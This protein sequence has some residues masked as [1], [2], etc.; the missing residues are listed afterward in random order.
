MGLHVVGGQMMLAYAR[1]TASAR[2]DATS[3]RRTLGVTCTNR[4]GS[5][6]MGLPHMGQAKL[7]SPIVPLTRLRAR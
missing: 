4:A 5:G 2:A 3:I 1:E 6:N 7:A